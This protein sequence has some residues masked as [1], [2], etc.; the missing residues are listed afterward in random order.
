MENEPVKNGEILLYSDGGGKEFVN[1]V[2]RDE[3]FW[4]TKSSMA[5]LFD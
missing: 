4:M 3:T 1:V 5:E 2:F